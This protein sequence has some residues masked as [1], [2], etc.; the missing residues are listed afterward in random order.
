MRILILATLAALAG[1]ATASP[2]SADLSPAKP[3][4]ASPPASVMTPQGY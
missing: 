2:P 4:L 1:C 3:A